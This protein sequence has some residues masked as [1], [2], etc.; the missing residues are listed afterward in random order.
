[1]PPA[2]IIPSTR[3]AFNAILWPLVKGFAQAPIRKVSGAVSV[4]ISTG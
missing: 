3:N 1:L 4:T 2:I